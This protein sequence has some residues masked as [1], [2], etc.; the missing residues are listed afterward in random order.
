MRM[1]LSVGSGLLVLAVVACPAVLE[2]QTPNKFDPVLQP[3]TALLTGQ[4]NVIITAD[5]SASVDGVALLVQ[6]LG[7][8]VGRRLMLINSVAAS[9]PNAALAILANTAIVQHIALD[10][11]IVGTME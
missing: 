9:L 7:G 11:A 2:P 3:R 10:R 5:A 4:S 1:R 6:Q 8:T